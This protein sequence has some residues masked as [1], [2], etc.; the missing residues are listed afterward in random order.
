MLKCPE[1]GSTTI[2]TERRPNGNSKCLACFFHGKTQLFAVDAPNSNN[3]T[4][5]KSHDLM[6]EVHH[7]NRVSFKADGEFDV[8]FS[9]GRVHVIPETKSFIVR[10]G[11]KAPQE[12]PS[13]G[14]YQK[15][16][17]VKTNGMPIPPEDKFIV[18]RYN[19]GEK[20]DA[21]C[22][23]VLLR[24]AREI[25]HNADEYPELQQFSKELKEDIAK[26]RLEAAKP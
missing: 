2:E 21:L 22:R 18:L 17:I 7:G 13:E 14:L 23:S 8:M 11:V 16:N 5:E 20:W 4:P 26:Y 6:I 9:R 19:R 10:G 1:C 24:L 12:K 3:G 25:E 15:Y